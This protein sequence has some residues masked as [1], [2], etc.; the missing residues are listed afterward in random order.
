VWR[1]KLRSQF[2][3][4]WLLF[5]CKYVCICNLFIVII[6]NQVY[7]KKVVFFDVFSGTG[8]NISKTLESCAK[9]LNHIQINRIWDFY[10]FCLYNYLNLCIFF[11]VAKYN[12]RV[13]HGKMGLLIWLRQIE[14][15]YFMNLILIDL[16]SF[17]KGV[18][19]I[20]SNLHWFIKLFGYGIFIWYMNSVQI[21][22]ARRI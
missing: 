21:M 10:N 19:F 2:G 11:H 5:F 8:P 22:Y 1:Y 14:K 7:L 6:L 4:F 9:K 18:L 12:Y 20:I 17:K 15:R 3:S 16:L 13:S